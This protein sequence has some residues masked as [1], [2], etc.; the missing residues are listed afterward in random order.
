MIEMLMFIVVAH[1]IGYAMQIV[2]PRFR[3]ADYV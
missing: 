3:G 1:G 2:F